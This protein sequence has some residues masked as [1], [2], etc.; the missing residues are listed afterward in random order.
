M[1]IEKTVLFFEDRASQ[2]AI[3]LNWILAKE[4]YTVHS[5]ATTDEYV[6]C[7][8]ENPNAIVLMNL[9]VASDQL[10]VSDFFEAVVSNLKNLRLLL[11]SFSIQNN[12]SCFN[13]AI[14]N[15]HHFGAGLFHIYKPYGTH[16]SHLFGQHSPCPLGHV[17]VK[18][19]K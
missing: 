19:L 1:N 2:S 6:N 5:F 13:Q 9:E 10:D 12:L 15:R 11:Y 14:D 18:N 8:T 7:F 3:N 4:G 17:S 16:K